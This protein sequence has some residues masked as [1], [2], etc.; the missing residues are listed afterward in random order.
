MFAPP[1]PAPQA[2]ASSPQRDPVESGP[3]EQPARAVRGAFAEPFGPADDV[4]DGNLENYDRETSPV[5]EYDA[6][7]GGGRDWRR[8][9]PRIEGQLE[10]MRELAE[11]LGDQRAAHFMY[12][13]GRPANDG[14]YCPPPL[15][16][17]PPPNVATRRI[18]IGEML[19]SALYTGDTRAVRRSP[20]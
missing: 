14:M 10:G 12:A 1:A 13:P 7:A 4:Y 15:P 20:R 6:S 8:Y 16:P 17:A 3:G 5:W 18:A 9:P 19:E 11:I 2:S